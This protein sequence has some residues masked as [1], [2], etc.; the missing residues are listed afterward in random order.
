MK[1]IILLLI[2]MSCV[3]FI[4]CGKD[5]GDSKYFNGEIIIVNT[6]VKPDTLHGEKIVLNGIYT[7]NMWAYD[8]L[9]GFVYGEFPGY[10]MHVF[11]I[12]TGKILYPLC[13]RGIGPE[14]F[15]EF[16]WTAQFTYDEHI[17]G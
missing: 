17:Y 6:D 12:K 13:K 9:I 14:E 2:S 8:T 7:G 1:H 16:T 5:G 15:P 11:N 4:S 3:L 10:F